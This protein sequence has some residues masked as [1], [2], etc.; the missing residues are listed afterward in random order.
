MSTPIAL[1]VDPLYIAQVSARKETV[2]QNGSAS[3]AL[4]NQAFAQF[5]AGF[6]KRTAEIA[7]MSGSRK[8]QIAVFLELVSDVRAVAEPFVPCA[9]GCSACC[10]QRVTISTL[11]AEYIAFNTGRAA[12]RVMPGAPMKPIEAFGRGTPCTFLDGNGECSIYDSRPYMCRNYV[13]LDIDNLL[14]QT[15]NIQL[16]A[17][18]HPA[19]T[20]VPILGEGPLGILYRRIIK[21]DAINDIRVFFS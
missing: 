16:T 6:E 12:K 18:R 14:C 9:K 15:E 1:Q 10:Y 13:T 4:I 20:G 5:Q 19:S 21:A 7:N 3:A 8:K 17:E 11:E 2:A